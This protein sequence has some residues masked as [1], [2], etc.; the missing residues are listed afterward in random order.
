MF[1]DSPFI[2]GSHIFRRLSLLSENTMN[3]YVSSPVKIGVIKEVEIWSMRFSASLILH[4]DNIE[5]S[6]VFDGQ[7]YT[8]CILYMSHM[9]MFVCI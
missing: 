3:L 5:N 2:T 4:N 9:Y 8:H 6:K 1:R 7:I